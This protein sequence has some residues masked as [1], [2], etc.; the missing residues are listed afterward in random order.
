MTV[1]LHSM[2]KIYLD[3]IVNE[4]P[5]VREVTDEFR[6]HLRGAGGQIDNYGYWGELSNGVKWCF[7]HDIPC[8]IETIPYYA[9]YCYQ[10]QKESLRIQRAEA[11]AR[12]RARR[13]WWEF[14]K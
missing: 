4:I 9:W 14:W 6:W 8:C 1:I 10:C 5:P 12:E 11:L 3:H 7:K 13:K 2:G